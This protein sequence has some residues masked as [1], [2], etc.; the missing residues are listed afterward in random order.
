MVKIGDF[1]Y[2]AAVYFVPLYRTGQGLTVMPWQLA[3]YTSTEAH[4]R[5]T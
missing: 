5:V 3:V 4:G 1:A 2:F